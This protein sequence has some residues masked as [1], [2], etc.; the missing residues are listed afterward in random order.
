[1]AA[2]VQ[3]E[4]E[5]FSLEEESGLI[6]RIALGTR[7]TRKRTAVNFVAYSSGVT[8]HLLLLDMLKRDVPTDLIKTTLSTERNP[9]SVT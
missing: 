1:V 3:Q 4:K 6:M 7:Y 8:R 2:G 5:A 9:F